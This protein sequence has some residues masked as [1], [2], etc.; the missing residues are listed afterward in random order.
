MSGISKD[1]A[2]QFLEK[3]GYKI[4]PIWRHEHYAQSEYLRKLFTY[5]KID[6]VFDVGANDGQYGQFLR[7]EVGFNGTIISFEP[8]P[9]S[10][11]KLRKL[12]E[13]DSQWIIKPYALGKT[14]S[15]AEFNIMKESQFS[16]FLEP[17]HDSVKMFMDNN[18][19][20]EKIEVDVLTLAEIMPDLVKE[21]GITSPYLKLDTQGFDLEVARGAGSLL[22][23]FRAL[24][25]EAS[26][27]Q[28]YKGMPSYSESIQTY[29]D[30]GFDLSG[31]FPN[32]PGHFPLL[33]E[34][35]LHMI[36]RDY[37]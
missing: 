25:S 5:L 29:N 10:I 31:I 8:I 17:S 9:S 32:N 21:Y 34:F 24:Q 4:V 28:I 1:L 3:M 26:V 19:V 16:S 22:S 14:R 30:M 37:I 23:N 11:E 13:S 35:D 18:Q 36:N 12:S 15:K 20:S 7:H 27:K 6:C 2:V 33:I